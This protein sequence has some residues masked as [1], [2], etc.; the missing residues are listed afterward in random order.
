MA[1]GRVLGR[2]A[3]MHTCVALGYGVKVV[4]AAGEVPLPGAAC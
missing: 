4:V 1:G 3:W 2:T